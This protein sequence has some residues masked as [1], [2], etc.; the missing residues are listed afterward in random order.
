MKK[1]TSQ[2]IKNQIKSQYDSYFNSV[3]VKM[4]HPNTS[5][6]FYSCKLRKMLTNH[7]DFKPYYFNYYKSSLVER[8]L[9]HVILQN[10]RGLNQRLLGYLYCTIYQLNS[11]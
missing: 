11:N 2:K 6:T 5:T 4:K 9:H 1:H 7:S 10:S 8:V 3:K